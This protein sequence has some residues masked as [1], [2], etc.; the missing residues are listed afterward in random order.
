MRVLIVDIDQKSIQSILMTFI[1]REDIVD[2]TIDH[3][4]ARSLWISIEADLII[5]GDTQHD[6]RTSR[7]LAQIRRD[8]C[9]SGVIVL[10]DAGYDARARFLEL[11]ADDVMTTPVYSSELLARGYAVVR[12][13]IGALCSSVIEAGGLEIN[14]AAGTVM[15]E[16]RQIHMTSKE[17]QLLEAL[18]LRKGA[19]VTKERL[20][21]RMYDLANGGPEIRIIDVYV[22]RVRDK[23]SKATGG[24]ELISNVHGQGYRFDDPERCNVVR[25]ASPKQFLRADHKVNRSGYSRV[26]KDSQ[27]KGEQNEAD[28]D[29]KPK[30]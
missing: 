12:R 2:A 27:R 4:E 5:I 11:G 30:R 19:V 25:V 9:N 17:L 10:T 22:F 24:L 1:R 3:E 23:I 8:K 7:L 14:L 18:A 29:E 13:R 26:R 15:F 28:R 6:A 20:L 16:G 21:S